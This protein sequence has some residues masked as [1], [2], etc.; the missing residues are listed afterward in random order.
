LSVKQHQ[1]A[2]GVSNFSLDVADLPL[3]IY[4]VDV[5]SEKGFKSTT[6]FLKR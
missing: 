4:M 5:M 1:A 2:Q 6:K 3:G